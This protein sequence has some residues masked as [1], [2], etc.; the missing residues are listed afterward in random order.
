M[1]SQLRMVCVGI[2][3][4]T[5]EVLL[6]DSSFENTWG[7]GLAKSIAAQPEEQDFGDW[8]TLG[9]LDGEDGLPC[10]PLFHGCI[11]VVDAESYV[12]GWKAATELQD[13]LSGREDEEF[14]RYGGA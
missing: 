4:P 10:D 13:L 14:I 6:S 11:K 2:Y 12:L 5:R 7:E 3:T 9:E 1:N 8:F